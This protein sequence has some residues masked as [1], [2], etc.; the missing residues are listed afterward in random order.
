MAHGQQDQI[1]TLACNHPTTP[2]VFII[3]IPVNHLSS[4]RFMLPYPD[5]VEIESDHCFAVLAPEVVVGG[6]TDSSH[7]QHRYCCPAEIYFPVFG[8]PLGRFKTFEV[9]FE[10]G[11]KNRYQRRQ[12]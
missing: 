12:R 6:G 11:I 10:A 8:Q 1:N 2:E 5:F 3:S 4:C 9:R 7:S